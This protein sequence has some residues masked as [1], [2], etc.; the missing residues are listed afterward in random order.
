MVATVAVLQGAASAPAQQPPLIRAGSELVLVPV[1]PLDKH[2][3]VI[4]GLPASDFRLRVDG[5][6]VEIKS[7]DVVSGAGAA[8]PAAIAPSPTPARQIYSNAP[9]AYSPTGNLVIFLVDYM[10]T[11]QILRLELRKHL[12][13][14]FA[15][16]LQPG[17]EIAVYA[18]T[19]SL[20]VV[21]PFTRDPS[22]LIAVAQNLLHEKG[23]PPNPQE[24]PTPL[25]AAVIAM[26]GSDAAMEVMEL[27][28]A[29]QAYNLDQ[30]IRARRTLEAF[31]QLAGAFAG[32]PGK[33]TVLW[34]TADP[35]PLNPTLT[36][37]MVL[38]N[39]KLEATDA[40]WLDLAKT[41]EALNRA[42]MSLCP[43]DVRGEVNTGL[44]DWANHHSRSEFL[45]DL[46]QSQPADR[47][48]YS[49]MTDFRQG[50]RANA[51]LAMLTAAA[52]TGGIVYQGDNDLVDLLAR[53]QELGS[54]YYVLGFDPRS[55]AKGNTPTY[56]HI[57]VKVEG[58]V[59]RVLARRGFL[60]Q[61]A[62][63][64]TSEAETQRELAEASESPVD[65]TAVPLIL[66]LAEPTQ[67]N[68]E[69]RI[70]FS[71]QIRG[72]GLT[73]AQTD[74]GYRYQLSFVTSVR[75]RHGHVWGSAVQHAAT[76][77]TPQQAENLAKA[78]LHLQGEFRAPP[79]DPSTGR[80][81]VRDDLTGR[82]GTIT[83]QLAGD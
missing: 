47:N 49:N 13:E 64:A 48:V 56:H 34:L 67:S 15:H 25:S 62:G 7:F 69:R 55:V 29:R 28:Y 77:I 44:S 8:A 40:S 26:S 12:L 19:M 74:K 37:Q 30:R 20:A 79:H 32:V 16:R 72:D 51:T 52:E 43:V 35:S 6:P 82:I 5:K 80:V 39:P 41:F 76:D 1:S 71:L 66:T 10:N 83:V 61:P 24:A 4:R 14:F 73:V 75:D 78:G 27:T 2:E 54:Y 63:A 68:N 3:R 42:G 50:E 59:A 57:E 38:D 65:L 23:M 11:P 17:Q 31:R 18:L 21:Q 22:R 70:P 81:V 53:A 33:K 9:A 58:H 60:V 36:N 46:A 45:Q